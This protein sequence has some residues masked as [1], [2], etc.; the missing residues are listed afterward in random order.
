MI[1]ANKPQLFSNIANHMPKKPKHTHRRVP[2]SALFHPIVLENLKRF[3]A[4]SHQ[5]VNDIL[6]DSMMELLS[7]RDEDI[8]ICIDPILHHKHSFIAGRNMQEF[9][10]ELPDDKKPLSFTV[11]HPQI[12]KIVNLVETEPE[13][14]NEDTQLDEQG[15]PY[16]KGMPF[17]EY[18]AMIQ[19]R[20]KDG[21]PPLE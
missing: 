18:R 15:R 9:R 8:N 17:E 6:H 7:L 13:P 1:Y 14:A 4:E 12:R 10:D 2:F 16:I 11:K 21:L 19:Q 5:S 20:I 3:A